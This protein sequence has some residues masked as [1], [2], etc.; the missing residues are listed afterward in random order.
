LYL[1]AQDLGHLIIFVPFKFVFGLGCFF[2]LKQNINDMP[3]TPY[4]K[5][6]DST[7]NIGFD[8]TK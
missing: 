1:I 6:A 4:C 7:E 3:T 2:W 5:R 8:P